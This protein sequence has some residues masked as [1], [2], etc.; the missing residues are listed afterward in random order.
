M[1]VYRYDTFVMA[2]PAVNAM[3]YA[4]EKPKMLSIITLVQLPVVLL[5]DYGLIPKI[6]VMAP[7]LAMALTNLMMM[8]A[9]YFFVLKRLGKI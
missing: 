4:F 8:T 2:T 9:S 6:G 1:D 7:V 5:I 3:V